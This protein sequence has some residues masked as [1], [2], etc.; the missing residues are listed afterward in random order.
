MWYEPDDRTMILSSVFAGIIARTIPWHGVSMPTHT[1]L[2]PS[3]RLVLES[4]T[5]ALTDADVI[6]HY[7]LTAADHMFI[8]RHRGPQ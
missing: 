5:D 3:Q 4:W 2:T 7:W 6:G 1:V 8:N